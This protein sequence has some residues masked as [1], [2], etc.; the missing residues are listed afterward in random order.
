[1]PNLCFTGHE[2]QFFGNAL[3]RLL[4]KVA[5]VPEFEALRIGPMGD[6]PDF[7]GSVQRAEDL[8][9]YEAGLPIHQVRALAEGLL[10][11]DS[12]IIGD[13]EFAERDERRC[14]LGDSEGRCED[15][16]DRTKGFRKRATGNFGHYFEPVECL[17]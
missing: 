9:A 3:V 17:Y 14:P 4:V 8:H 7:L 5:A 12:L 2:L 10:N 13:H 1:M 15:G 11:L 16:A 6:E